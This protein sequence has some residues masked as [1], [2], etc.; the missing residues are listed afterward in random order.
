MM[1]ALD[2]RLVSATI[3]PPESPSWRSRPSA[4]V[5]AAIAVGMSAARL[6]TW[7][8]LPSARASSGRSAAGG[9]AWLARSTAARSHRRASARWTLSDQNGPRRVARP[10]SRSGSS[11]PAAH[12]RAC[13]MLS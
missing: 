12:S 7:A 6:A 9:P 5:P 4:A 10:S 8:R 11:W 1:V 3:M 13:R 2:P